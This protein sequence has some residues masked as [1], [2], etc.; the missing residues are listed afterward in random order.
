[1]VALHLSRRVFGQI[2]VNF[3]WAMGYNLFTIPFAAGVFYHWIEWR[4]PPAFAGFMMA[5]S[6]VSVVTNSLFLKCYSKPK[7][8][9]DGSIIEQGHFHCSKRRVMMIL[10]RIVFY[11]FST[12]RE[13]SPPHCDWDNVMV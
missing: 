8:D 3:F 9:D 1:V 10:N 4:I 12:E 13:T 6:S 2:K 11:T 7:I 5:F